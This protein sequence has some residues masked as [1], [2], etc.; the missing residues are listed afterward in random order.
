MV[1]K[2][3]LIPL[4]ALFII[5]PL[6]KA[7][8]TI[9]IPLGVSGGS[10]S[11]GTGL[12]LAGSVFSVMSC[13][14]NDDVIKYNTG[15]SLWYCAADQTGAGG[16][17]DLNVSGDTGSGVITDSEVLSIL[18]LNDVTTIMSGNAL[19]IDVT[20]TDSNASTAC[21]TNSEFLT[22]VN[23]CNSTAGWDTIMSDDFSGAW[24][25]LTGVPAGFSDNIDNNTIYL[26]D[27]DCSVNDRLLRRA[28]GTWA[29]FDDA[30]YY[31]DTTISNCS[32]GGSCGLITYTTGATMTG[33]LVLNNL[34][35]YSSSHDGTFS[36]V[37]AAGDMASNYFYT[38]P[39][40]VPGE[41][42]VGQP[43]LSVTGVNGNNISLGWI[44]DPVPIEDHEFDTFNPDYGNN[45]VADSSGDTMIW[46]S[47]G[48][49]I[50]FTGLAVSDTMQADI[51]QTVDYNFTHQNFTTRQDE[52]EPVRAFGVTYR[53]NWTRPIMV[54]GSVQF[55]VAVTSGAFAEAWTGVV[56][57]NIRK[58]FF[59]P[60][61]WY[62][63]GGL[64]QPR[65]DAHNFFFIV[66]PQDYY[67][68]NTTTNGGGTATLSEWHE[69]LL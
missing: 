63:Y 42:W 2:K 61:A 11:A 1:D 9:T 20:D 26:L 22:G 27:D 31:D 17:Y 7:Q 18:G 6:T 10:Y 49:T 59:G 68:I 8:D 39:R 15:S 40:S 21:T 65:Y 23:T 16:S 29:C 62:P 12:S 28:T 3:V 30:V 43:R 24:G 36:F 51:N 13:P 66:Q 57:P 50:D 44:E 55:L 34:T 60:V 58:Q 37:S 25:D 56:T 46:T 4:I 69:V 45:I 33:P 48:S 5:I 64:S 53:N 19:T 32:V 41:P 67:K 38:W 14:T 47:P 54:Y 52:F 35:F